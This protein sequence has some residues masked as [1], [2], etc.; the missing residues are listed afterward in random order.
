[1]ARRRSGGPTINQTRGWL[2]RIARIMGDAQA[3]QSGRAGRRIGRRVAG[4]A[5]GRGLGRLLR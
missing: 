1:M 5:T 4:R 2:Y 3:I